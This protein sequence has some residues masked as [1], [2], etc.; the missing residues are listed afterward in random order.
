MENKSFCQ[1]CGM[2]LDS[3]ELKGTEKT[4]LK[5]EEY[6]K[7]CYEKGKLKDANMTLN[8]MKN[9]VK[10]QMQLMKLP[11]HSIQKAIDYLPMLKRWKT[12]TV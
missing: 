11:E 5:S 4:G 6:C 8:E 7:Y 12:K 10:N 9:I 1:S 2:P 3:E